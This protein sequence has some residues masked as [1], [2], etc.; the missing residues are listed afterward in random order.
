MKARRAARVR[1]SFILY[2][3]N[4]MESGGNIN[5]L[6]A[7]EAAN[8]VGAKRFALLLGRVLQGMVALKSTPSAIFNETELNQLV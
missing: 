5:V 6:D 7:V 2:I 1:I 4:N 3:F 8:K